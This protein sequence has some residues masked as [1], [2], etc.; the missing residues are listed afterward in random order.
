MR[1]ENDDSLAEV[2]ADD[3]DGANEISISADQDE[4]VGLVIERIHQH[5]RGDIHV[6]TFFFQLDDAAQTVLGR[7]A[8]FA[9]GF[10]NG[11]PGGVLAV[12][13]LDD[14]DVG[15]GG[16]RLKVNFCRSSGAAS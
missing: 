8:R 7:V 13:S 16:K 10:V 14:F 6:G 1:I 9:G 2:F 5:G 11:K 4:H 12:E 3:V 15:Q